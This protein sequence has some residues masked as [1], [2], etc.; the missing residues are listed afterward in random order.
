MKR[1]SSF[2]ELKTS[3]SKSLD[4]KANTIALEQ[5]LKQFMEV[6]KQAKKSAE[7]KTYAKSE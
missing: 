3:E 1:F 5:E 2:N 4:P 7:L 6:L